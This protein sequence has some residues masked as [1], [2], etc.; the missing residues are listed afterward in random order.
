M[1][2]T[3]IVSTESIQRAFKD[4]LVLFVGQG[5]R[6]PISTVAEL[7]GVNARNLYAYQEGQNAAPFD[8]IFSV[9]AAL[10]DCPGFADAVFAPAGLSVGHRITG[11]EA[12]AFDVV[13][14]LARTTSEAAARAPGGFNHKERADL[15]PIVREAVCKLNAL[16]ED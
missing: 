4:A 16:L 14:A 5:K 11:D 13:Q 8:A 10:R 3:P 15:K 9:C 1:K 2:T 6:F 12:E 7:S